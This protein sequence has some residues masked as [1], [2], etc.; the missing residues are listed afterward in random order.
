MVSHIILILLVIS[1]LAGCNAKTGDELYSEG[2]RTLQAGNPG[3]AI[4]LLRSSLERNQFNANAYH[5][6]SHAYIAIGKY[7]L[8]ERE[9]QKVR[10]MEPGRTIV[11]LELAR[12]YNQLKKP[13]QAIT[14]AEEY[15]EKEPDSAEALE[16]IGNAYILKGELTS[17]EAFLVRAVKQETARQ[18]PRLA[19]ATHYLKH[20]KPEQVE[21]VLQTLLEQNQLHPVAGVLLAEAEIALGR[22]EHARYIF[23]QLTSA[24]TDDPNI[25]YKAGLLDLELGSVDRAEQLADRLIKQFPQHSEGYRLKGFVLFSRKEYPSAIPVLQRAN[26]LQ[27]TVAGYYCLGLSLYQTSDLE[28]SMNQ[29]RAIL[30][31][32]PDFQQ[33]RLMT[34]AILLRQNRLDD[35]VA[36]ATRLVEAHPEN[37]LA[38]N[39][40]GSAYLSKGLVEEGIDSLDRSV[41]L[42]PR[43]ADSYL[44]KGVALINNGKLKEAL[45]PLQKAES[46][47]PGTPAVNFYLARAHRGLGDRDKSFRHLQTALHAR[48]SG[49][50]IQPWGLAA[51][52]Y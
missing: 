25:H 11:M 43:L 7:E 32:L 9:L 12:L 8:A 45:A 42:D 23:Q 48:E 24:H 16:V 10:R 29:F 39:L 38:H 17:G 22:K 13:D 1:V 30:E 18:S 35:S 3:G 50:F 28:S 49:A 46:L 21:A 20:G 47:L 41:R 31:Q 36:E 37:A 6:L 40:L 15:R 26:K 33:A 14:A 19:L 2:V 27:P 51:E 34:A 44:K 52:H 5:Q 4:V